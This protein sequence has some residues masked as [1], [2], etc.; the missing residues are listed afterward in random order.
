MLEDVRGKAASFF[1]PGRRFSAGV[2]AAALGVLCTSAPARAEGVPVHAASAAQRQQA[3]RHFD[4][5]KKLQRSGRLE[6]ALAAFRAAHEIVASPMT[7]WMI[8]RTRR[9]LG[10]LAD[11]EVDYRAALA[12]AEAAVARDGRHQEALDA[13]RQDLR[14]LEGILGWLTIT[15]IHAPQGTTV[16][17]DGAPV[18]ASKLG[19][20]I[21]VAPGPLKVVATAPDGKEVGREISISAGQSATLKLPF[22]REKAPTTFF[23]VEGDAAAEPAGEAPEGSAASSRGA[24]TWVYVTGGV[25]VLG[26]GAFTAFGLMS[27]AKF[28]ELEEACPEDRCPSARRADIDDGKRFQTFA[29]V[30][31]AVGVAGLGTAAALLLFGG[32][33]EPEAKPAAAELRLGLGPGA[34]DLYGS[35]E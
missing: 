13:I 24:R 6:E 16:T 2:L 35:F 7:S 4:R 23:A 10:E 9:D 27:T 1:K 29:N 11:A 20:P 18:E 21:R 17:L 25:G 31:L 8:A 32:S 5:A 26:L 22:A 14:E 15:L 33:S 34:I 19:A 30:G 12:E 3:Q 28:D